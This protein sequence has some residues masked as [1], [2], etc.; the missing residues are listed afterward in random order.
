MENVS[1]NG[2][3][4][5]HF[6]FFS[7][8]W[9]P[10]IFPGK[11]EAV[12]SSLAYSICS[13]L[14]IL[15][16]KGVSGVFDSTWTLVFFQTF[17]ATVLH[18][19]GM[20]FGIIENTGYSFRKLGLVLPLNFFFV[21]MLYTNMQ[22]ILHLSIPMI[23]VYK[24]L[25][26]FLT[27]IG[28]SLAN[29]RSVACGE[30]LSL[31]CMLAGAVAASF[32]DLDFNLAGCLWITT[33]SVVQTLYS[34]F[35]KFLQN[36]K[37]MSATSLSIYNNFTSC[38][39]LMFV[40]SMNMVICGGDSVPYCLKIDATGIGY[41]RL[42]LLTSSGIMGTLLGTCSFW[43]ISASSPSN[44]A[45]VGA[46][47]KIPIT[48]FGAL[49]FEVHIDNRGWTFIAMNMIGG[50]GYAI[51]HS[52]NY[53]KIWK[54]L[55]KCGN[56]GPITCISRLAYILVSL[57]CFVSVS[58]YLP[59]V[60]RTHAAMELTL[61]TITPISHLSTTASSMFSQNKNFSLP[62][63]TKV[64]SIVSQNLN[65]SILQ[66]KPKI[67][68]L[69]NLLRVDA[70]PALPM[71]TTGTAHVH[72]RTIAQRESL[73]RVTRRRLEREVHVEQE[74]KNVERPRSLSSELHHLQV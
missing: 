14:M 20:S 12:L 41:G 1:T 13:V 21:I 67:S 57:A 32:Y 35:A 23:V 51:T 58:L 47:N 40:H 17:C 15:C 61:Q 25:S 39:V 9:K 52:Y 46:L 65:I 42:V 66:K 71:T 30:W 22:A 4:S 56:I 68:G 53:A 24:N 33:N 69:I 26:T 16:N 34:L 6:T 54:L 27:V 43:C 11:T 44:F 59:D 60:G 36:S 73:V 45:I 70:P 7:S 50:F 28:D 48:L 72:R 64:K 37:Q 19:I 8:T 74:L 31:T 38:V 29:D 18:G 55:I 62:S 49:L 5:G 10:S 63:L 2:P 3:S